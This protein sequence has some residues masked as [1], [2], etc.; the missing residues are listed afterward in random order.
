MVLCPFTA[1]DSE[2]P[3]LAWCLWSTVPAVGRW[4]A[5]EQK[6]EVTLV[7]IA[8]SNL[9]A[10]TNKWVS[11]FLVCPRGLRVNQKELESPTDK[12]NRNISFALKLAGFGVR[13]PSWNYAKS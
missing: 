11:S 9:K 13:R 12:S 2:H 7:Y 10:P 4:R 3:G 5:E 6:F 1:R 8:S